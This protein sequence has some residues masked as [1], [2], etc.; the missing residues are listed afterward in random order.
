[1]FSKWAHAFPENVETWIAHYPGRGSRYNEPPIKK[2]GILIEHIFQAVQPLLDKPFAFWGHSLGGLVAYELSQSLIRNEGPQP[3]ALFISACGA[4]HLPDPHP[5]IHT[6]PDP[7][8]VKALWGFNGTPSEVINHPELMELL[9]PTLRAD[10]EAVE[11]YRYN[12]D[13]RPLICPIIALGGLEDARVSR[14]RLEGWGLHT[15]ADFIS[16]YFPGDHFFIHTAREAVI[17]PITSELTAVY[18]ND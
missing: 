12:P 7:E 9:L 3:N 11:S 15:E 5:P 2:L 8:F 13:D 1:M 4:P 18:A 14:E 6:L 16:L 10:F 17:A